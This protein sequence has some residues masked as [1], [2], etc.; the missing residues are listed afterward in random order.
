MAS[1]PFTVV[2]PAKL[3]IPAPESVRLLNA[4]RCDSDAYV[5]LPNSTVRPRVLSWVKPL[6]VSEPRMRSVSLLVYVPPTVSVLP[7]RSSD[8]AVIVRLPL[9][10][11]ASPRV[12]VF[13]RLSTTA[14]KLEPFE[15]TVALPVP[16]EGDGIG[17]GKG[18][19]AR[20]P[21]S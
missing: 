10:A 14:A 12:R 13:D 21:R 1:V 16:R 2:V 20:I 8:P 11:S 15:V 6:V 17:A 4:V 18:A 9:V 5:P 7:W 3:Q 19:V